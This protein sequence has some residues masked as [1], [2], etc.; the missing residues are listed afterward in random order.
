MKNQLTQTLIFISFLFISCSQESKVK[1]SID[2]YVE[3]N[4]ND[5]GSY[6]LVDLKLFDTINEQ[7]VSKYLTNQRLEKQ[8]KSSNTLKKKGKNIQKLHRMLCLVEIIIT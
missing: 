8:K 4:F 1:N 7:K 5:P 6:E 3:K 2:K